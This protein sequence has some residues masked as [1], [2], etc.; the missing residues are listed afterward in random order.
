MDFAE[1]LGNSALLWAAIRTIGTLQRAPRVSVDGGLDLD[2]F[3]DE[4]VDIICD[5]E[6]RAETVD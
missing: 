6:D 5:A 1:R 3:I 4:C 2:R